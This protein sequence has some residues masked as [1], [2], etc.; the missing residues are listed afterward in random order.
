MA[1]DA[2]TQRLISLKKLAG[3]A[4]TS[5]D[6]DLANEALPSGVTMASSTIFSDAIT[7]SPSDS[8]L[9]TITGNV[10]YIRFPVSFILGSN[11]INGRHGFELKLPS[12][13]ESNSS[14]PRAGTAP[15]IN[16]QVINAT[17]GELQIV[18]TSFSNSY[19][20]KPFFGGTSAKGSGTQI[21]LLDDRDWYL[22]S[23]NG[24]LFQQDPP[25]TGNHAE[26]PTFVEAYLYIGNRLSETIA[27]AGGDPT[28]QYLVLATTSSLTQE[29]AFN[30]TIGLT[31]S[32]GGAGA[33]YT[34]QI[35]NSVVA[36]LTGSQFSGNVGITA[37]LGV[38]GDLEV[39]EHIKHIGDNDTFIQFAN[40]A[41]GFTAGGEQLLTVSEAG[42]DMVTVGDGGDV[43]FRVRT[44]NDDNTLYI[45]GSTDRIGVGTNTPSSIIHVKE[46]GPTLT[47]QRENNSNAS[48]I[49]FLGAL[50]NTANSITHD[51]STNDLVFKTFNGT[52]VEEIMRVG[53][54]Y[55]TSVRQVTFL[56]GSNMPPPAMQPRSTSDISF[57]VSGAIGSI[58][59][60]TRGV[61]VFGGDTVVSGA[62][63]AP[64]GISGSLQQLTDGTSYLRQGPGVSIV[65]SSAGHVTI[66]A[67]GE[68]RTKSVHFLTTDESANTSISVSPSDFSAANY[69]MQKIDVF[70]NGQ[71]LHSGSSVQVSAGE[72]DYYIDTANSLRFSFDTKIDDI[73][74]VIVYTVV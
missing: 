58:G 17:A 5:N 70:I 7:P 37:S 19:E 49:N 6:K 60:S 56:S 33:N 18:P 52:A 32:D 61:S 25:G 27:S 53:D 23:F 21:P 30:P 10:E 44:E 71:L 41:I 14:N 68:S 35:D 55:G 47:L 36:T 72:R 43:D 64:G 26:N 8:A 62:I 40:D 51:S 46:A 28:A 15:F 13:Y 69:D 9:Y 4:Q 24:I 38:L 45:E 67:A 63:H 12:D 39:A 11:T 20:P 22:D 66:S 50:G 34:L 57:F 74:D 2:K 73:L 3:K 42:T 48:T 65:S 54:H 59:T 1:Y 29:R 31:S 16:G